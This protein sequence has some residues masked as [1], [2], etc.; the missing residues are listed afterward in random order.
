MKTFAAISLAS[1]S[2][3]NLH[4]FGRS[5]GPGA[6]IWLPHDLE[7]AMETPLLH[8][9]SLSITPWFV[10]KSIVFLLI[11]AAISRITR[12]ILERRVLPRT[13]MAP[14]Q[15]YALA[16]WFEYFVFCV[17]MVIG[18]QTSGLNL[19]SVLV[20]GGALG[21][22]IGFGLQ[23]VAN[24]F[25]SGLILLVEQPVRVGDII[26]VGQ[27][28]GQ[29]TRIG[30]RSTSVRT[31]NN[32]RIIVPN[33]D[34]IQNRVTNWTGPAASV[35]VD[36]KIGVGYDSNPEKVRE[37]LLQ[38][39]RQHPQALADPAPG[40]IFR[41]FGDSSLN[42]DLYVWF[43]GTVFQIGGFRSDLNF[44]IYRVMRENGIE[45]PFPQRD[46]HIRSVDQPVSVRNA[47]A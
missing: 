39:A 29:V 34:L 31:G 20:V 12:R 32:A 38:V 17:G 10:V 22:G 9:G 36:A 45:I 35:L 37:L 15:Q 24:N 28:Q 40:V 14:G 21:V 47:G 8:L 11:V 6:V 4:I 5:F 30:A 41:E 26:E 16:R 23:N 13:S 7:R 25:I 46:L 33:A 1:V 27:M 18:L 2:V 43:P 44:A 19:N 3:S 42:F